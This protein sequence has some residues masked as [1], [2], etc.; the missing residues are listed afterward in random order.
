MLHHCETEMICVYDF[1]GSTPTKYQ[2]NYWADWCPKCKIIQFGGYWFPIPFL[3]FGRKPDFDK[4]PTIQAHIKKYEDD[5]E[6]RY[7]ER[8]LEW[9]T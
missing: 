9:L 1:C 4:S 8:Y 2:V 3:V 7:K 5:C 6:Q